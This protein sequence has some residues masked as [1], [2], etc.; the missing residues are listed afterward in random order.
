[1]RTA[2][3]DSICMIHKNLWKNGSCIYY[4][5][6]WSN[7]NLLHSSEYTTFLTQSYQLLNFFDTQIAASIYYVST[8]SLPL[9]P[10]PIWPGVVATARVLF[11]GQIELFHI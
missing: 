1:M 5:P 6:A 2:I 4:L 10:G 9:L 7:F 11:M 8:P 3:N